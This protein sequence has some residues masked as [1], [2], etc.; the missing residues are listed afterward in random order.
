MIGAMKLKRPQRVAVIGAG[1]SGATCARTL[2]EAGIDVHLFDKRRGFGGRLATRRME[3][4]D[5]QG[6]PQ[7]T[8]LDHGAVGFEARSSAFQ[9]LVADA[10]ESGLLALWQPQ[11][12]A[13]GLSA[14]DLPPLYVPVPDMPA[15]CRCLADGVPLVTG[16]DV[17]NVQC[18]P[19]GWMLKAGSTFHQHT[20]DAVLLAMPPAQA[21]TLLAPHR[22][23]WARQAAVTPML[24]GWTLMGVADEPAQAPDWQA[25]RPATGPLAWIIRHES[26]PGRKT[27]AGQSHWVAH[28]RPSWSRQHLEQPAS[29]V[30]AELQSAMEHGVGHALRWQH[31]QVH[32]W[33]YALPQPHRSMPT[34]CSW[35][36]PQLGLGV[37]G[38]FLGGTGA[39]GAW[40]S[41]R[42]LC[43]ALLLRPG[44]AEQSG[45]A[46][47]VSAASPS[48]LGPGLVSAALSP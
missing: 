1:L 36:D 42:A 27:V 46:D 9:A 28:A 34:D 5:R 7:S 26:R 12:P 38:D 29:W 30:Q 10:V 22:E 14:A 18:T 17:D 25:A 47:G 19:A 24:P 40:L 45:P 8:R 23:D 16:F 35:W 3:W 37:C 13:D 11:L 44:P 41:A 21:A 4:V 15:L 2:A 20:F 32:R 43:A 31:V 6:Q 39:E 48:R 33:R